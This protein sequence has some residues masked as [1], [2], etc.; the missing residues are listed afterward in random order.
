MFYYILKIRRSYSYL[1]EKGLPRRLRSKESACQ[2]RSHR[3]HGF[4]PESG[5]SPGGDNGNPVFLPRVSIMDR[6]AWWAIVS[7][8][9]KSCT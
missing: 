9:A 2:C 7:G 3:R 4:N 6:G 8:V 5:R 1:K